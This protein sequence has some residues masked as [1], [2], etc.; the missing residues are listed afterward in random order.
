MNICGASF[1]TGARKLLV[2]TI[3]KLNRHLGGQCKAES[4]KVDLAK[5]LHV[6][7]DLEEMRQVDG[8][9]HLILDW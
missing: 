5:Q 3:L 2:A 6:W 7:Q 8:N 1:I 4:W 9:N